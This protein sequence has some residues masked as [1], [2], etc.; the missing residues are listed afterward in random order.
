V[1]LDG[2]LGTELIAAGL[3]AGRAPEWW[4]IEHP[5]RIAAVHRA[6]AEA[7]ADVV[8]ACTFG[9]NPLKLARDGLAGRCAEINAAAVA[10]CR[11]AVDGQALVS[12]NL[13]PTGELF[14][15]M[16]TAHADELRA[17]FREQAGLLAEAGVDLITVETMFDLRE[18]LLATEEAVAA[19]LPVL[20]SMTFSARKRGHFTIVGDRIGPSLRALAEAGASAVGF[21]CSVTSEPML[22]MVRE[23]VDGTDVAVMAQPNAGQPR[24]T[25]E[26]VVYDA[27]PEA[28]ARDLAAMVDAGARVVGGCCGTTPEF[29]RAARK[30]L[31][32]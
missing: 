16:G 1:L 17:S 29:I 6:Y 13:G 10:L 27:E 9:A 23:A 25:P 28:F 7:G 14:E 5:D 30:L 19:G 21:N 3:A 12:A 32:R 26:G 2:A 11:E 20:A 15:P 31:D 18:A 8:Q 4:V 24:A 22:A